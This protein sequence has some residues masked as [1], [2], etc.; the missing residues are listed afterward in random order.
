MLT[1]RSS[2]DTVRGFPATKRDMIRQPSAEDLDAAHQLVS[3][4]RGVADFR[5]DNFDAS[6]SPDGD[7]ASVGTGAAMDDAASSD[8][9][10]SESQQQQQ[11]HS[12]ASEQISAPESSSR[13][14]A[15]PKASRNTE[16]FLG[17]QCVNCGTK[18]TPLWRRSL[19]GSTICNACGL[20]LKARNTDR[21]TNRVRDSGANASSGYAN[22]STSDPR[23]S[24]VA[25]DVSAQ[26]AS[27]CGST[28]AGTCPGG[29]S[30]NGTGGAVGCDGCPAYNNRVY[31]AAPRAPSVRQARASP[32]A[33][34]SEEQAQSGLDALDSASQDASGMPKACQNCGTTLTPLWRRDDQGNT[35]CNACGLYYRLHGSHRPVA[36]KKTV[37]KRRKRVVP[38]L[39]D[40]S[41]GAGSSDNS[42]VSPELHSASLATSNADSNAYPSSENGGPSYGAAQFPHSAPPPIDFT[43]Y[44]SKPTQS[45]SS[46]GLNTLIN[47]SP[48][49]KKR[50]HSESTS[51]ESAPPA[52]RIQSDISASAHLPP[53]YPAS[54]RG[55][56]N[57]GRLSSISSLL[58]HTD[59]SFTE[60]HV[61]SALGSNPPARSQ[62]QTQPQPGSRS[63]S[64]NPVKTPS[65]QPAHGSHSIP[66]PSLTPT[67]D[68]NVKAARRAQ[69]QREAEKMREALR[70]KERE[71]ASLK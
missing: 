49:T 46:P 52:T 35:I 28:P 18:R 50:T 13:S 61:D 39:R 34:T 53:I 69:L 21:P 27:G 2:S 41:P 36:M 7:K 65:T 56:P 43:G 20:Y 6:R 44:Y 38:A 19:S 4:A 55:L 70:A 37:I 64:P 47:H 26:N 58:N 57:S 29:G 40:R 67:A 45:T 30:C 8:Q 25:S 63:Y 71:L 33:Q 59:P 1:L 66:P 23:A 3:S 60:S 11:Q 54:A 14:R 51:T 16:V 62:T 42:S 32:S 24:P 10:Q 12:Q 22:N 31:K 15:S 68:D 5:P 9:N 17:H 48:N